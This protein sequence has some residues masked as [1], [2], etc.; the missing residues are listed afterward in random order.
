MLSEKKP[1]PKVF[2]YHSIYVA[3]W[4]KKI[5]EMEYKLVVVRD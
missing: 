3:F 1:N 4:N 2:Y 5:L